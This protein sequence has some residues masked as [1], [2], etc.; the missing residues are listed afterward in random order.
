MFIRTQDR[1]QL[2][3]L[4][5]YT[6]TVFNNK[7]L[8]DK[9]IL[10]APSEINHRIIAKYSSN[11][12]AME[13]LDEICK[14]MMPVMVMQ[15]IEVDTEVTKLL[16]NSAILVRTGN[17]MPRVENMNCGVFEMPLE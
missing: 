6:L 7:I 1:T 8:A 2:L 9:D 10:S 5:G 11:E 3:N 14:A 12:R 17:D 15:D 16:D 4:D 13:V